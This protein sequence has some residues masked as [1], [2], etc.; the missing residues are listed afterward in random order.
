MKI[1]FLPQ[2]RTKLEK[3]N[4]NTCLERELTLD[5]LYLEFGGNYYLTI[6]CQRVLPGI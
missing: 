2:K 4:Q 6:R 3:N 5:K 1:G